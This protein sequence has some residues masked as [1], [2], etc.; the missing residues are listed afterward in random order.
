MV[1]F[2]TDQSIPL[3]HRIRE[4]AAGRPIFEPKGVIRCLGT[5]MFRT[6]AARDLACLLDLDPTVVAWQ[7]LPLLLQNNGEWHVP[8]FKIERS[9][10][11]SL[12]D[13]RRVPVWLSSASEVHGFRHEVISP[14]EEHFRFRLQNSKDLLRYAQFPVLLG[15]RVN[16]LTLLEEH[17]PAPLASCLQVVQGARDRMGVIA[18]LVLDRVL[19]M[20]LDQAPIGPET[21]VFR[22][23]R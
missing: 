11:I 10:E 15:D 9:E 19:E 22:A 12:V 18:S 14:D 8:D 21:R 16:L 3:L 13:A 4:P 6:R 2:S 17:G 1:A 23:L 20:D 5:A 7:C